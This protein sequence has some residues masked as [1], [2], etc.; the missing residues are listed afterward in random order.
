MDT[1]TQRLMLRGGMILVGALLVSTV[2]GWARGAS[3]DADRTPGAGSG[4]ELL[5]ELRT[6]RQQ[7]DAKQ[8]ELEVARL[9]LERANAIIQYSAHYRIPADLATAIY[10]VALSEG[11]DPG[12]A[13][14]LVKVESGFTQ[15]AKS[16]VGALGFTQVLPSTARLYEPGLTAEQLYDRDTNLRIGFRYLRDLLDRYPSNMSLALLAYN[17]GPGKVEELLGAGRDPQNGY[18]TSVMKGFRHR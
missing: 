1:K 18:A 16:K 15:R 17:R 5:G 8:G 3:A 13:F 12:L 10:D 9:Q 11:I 6:L 4:T 14:R 2:G 7:L